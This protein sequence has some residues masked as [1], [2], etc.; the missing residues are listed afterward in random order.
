M[1][2][3]HVMF[4]AILVVAL[5]AFLAA[6]GNGNGGS[7]NGGSGGGTIQHLDPSQLFHFEGT[8]TAI[9]AEPGA[10]QPGF[11]LTPVTGEPVTIQ[12]GPYWLF[13][14]EAFE[15]TEG[16][17]VAVDAFASTDPAVKVYYA[18]VIRNLTDGTE[19][20]LRGEDGR[21]LWTGGR[22]YQFGDHGRRGDRSG[23]PGGECDGS[24]NGPAEGRGRGR[25]GGADNGGACQLPD[26]ASLR[27][28]ASSVIATSFSL[29]ARACGFTLTDADGVTCAI[30]MGPAWY[31]AANSFD[32]QTGDV[33]TVLAANCLADPA[34]WIA[35]QVVNHTV[36]TAIVLRGEDGLPLWKKN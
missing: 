8:I 35:F 23:T 4:G 12:A 36:G 32:V 6:Q 2:R 24:G 30:A 19:L 14:S 33:V 3:M 18:A 31:L 22:R 17:A 25:Q 27:E 7:G 9:L 28:I 26:L 1:K 10:G 20:V 34:R 29:G 21:P 16:D 5:S 11:V 15:L 13:D